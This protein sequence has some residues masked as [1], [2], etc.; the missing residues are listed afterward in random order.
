[1]LTSLLSVAVAMLIVSFSH[2]RVEG[3]ALAKLSGIMM[4]GLPV[5]F[6][7]FSG[8]QY[9]FAPLPSFWIAKICLSE[10][11]FFLPCPRYICAAVELAFIRS[12]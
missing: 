5:P 6:F 7:L 12:L 11:A 4:L 10:N 1:M 8:A 3:M 2:N 9:L